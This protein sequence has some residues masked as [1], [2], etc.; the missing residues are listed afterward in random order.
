MSKGH[1]APRVLD[2]QRRHQRQHPVRRDIRAHDPRMVEEELLG[3]PRGL[4]AH[5]GVE[6]PGVQYLNAQPHGHV[7]PPAQHVELPRDGGILRTQ[8]SVLPRSGDS[9]GV[10]RMGLV[11]STAPGPLQERSRDRPDTMTMARGG[12]RWEHHDDNAT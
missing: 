6:L 9:R 10:A 12:P 3:R 2:A 5:L 8:A 1:A 4:D 11:S 7:N